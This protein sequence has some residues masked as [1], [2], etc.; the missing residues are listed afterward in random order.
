MRAN[1]ALSVLVA[2][3]IATAGLSTLGSAL[4]GPRLSVGDRWTYR[5]NTS[6]GARFFLA[7]QATLAVIKVGSAPVDG[8][9]VDAVRMS[10]NGAGSA[11]GNYARTESYNSTSE[12]ATTDL[13]SYRYQALET[14]RFVGLTTDQWVL[15]AVLGAAA[16]NGFIWWYRK[17]RPLPPQTRTPP[18]AGSHE[19]FEIRRPFLEGELDRMP[20]RLR[21]EPVAG[22]TPSDHF[23]LRNG[24]D[25]GVGPGPEL[26]RG[27]EVVNEVG[28]D[29]STAEGTDRLDPVVAIED[30]EIPVRNQDRQFQESVPSDLFG[31][32]LE[33][34][35]TNRLVGMQTVDLEHFEPDHRCGSNREVRAGH[36]NGIGPA[37]ITVSQS[38]G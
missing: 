2:F 7:G 12:V 30:H 21:R 27:R 24:G 38:E 14:P 3:A 17:R 1:R 4:T 26:D 15:V 25:D 11:A 22:Q 32:L 33:E 6:L 8:V 18:G 28:R 13:V 20:R 10:V 29:A 35:R 5:T 36:R 37:R 31:E 23:L 34:R 9:T 16:A 19:V